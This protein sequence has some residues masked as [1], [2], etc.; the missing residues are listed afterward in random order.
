MACAHLPHPDSALVHASSHTASERHD[1]VVD[2]VAYIGA[3]EIG[4][5]R[6]LAPIGD[7][8]RLALAEIGIVGRDGAAAAE[9]D[10]GEAPHAGMAGDLKQCTVDPVHRFRHLFEH[11]HMAG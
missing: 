8:L 11:E 3:A 5:S 2:V 6:S 1:L 10:P 4:N 7:D 9:P